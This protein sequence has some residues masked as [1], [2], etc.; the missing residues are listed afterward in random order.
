VAIV[1]YSIQSAFLHFSRQEVKNAEFG[2]LKVYVVFQITA[3]KVF[4]NKKRKDQ[5]AHYN[6]KQ[7]KNIL[8]S[9]S[10]CSGLVVSRCVSVRVSHWS[11]AVQ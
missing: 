4:L 6:I 2:H 8:F 5:E 3:K 9:S 10:A 1:H 7:S 11:A